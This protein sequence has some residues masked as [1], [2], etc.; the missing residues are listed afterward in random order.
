MK[1]I[2][3]SA[4]LVVSVLSFGSANAQLL[5]TLGK[6]NS[7]ANTA[8]TAA[9]VVDAAKGS[10]AGSGAG[11]AGAAAGIGASMPAGA[12]LDWTQFKQTPAIT[13][14]SLLYGTSIGTSGN[15]R[16][17][18][19]TATFVPNKKA[20]GGTIDAIRD[21][22][23]YLRVKVYKDGQYK[24]YFE[25][26]GTQTFDEGKKV[27][28]NGPTSR[29]QRAGE[30]VGDTDIDAKV[31]GVGNYRLDFFAG[32]KMF[33][34]FDFEIYKLSNPDTYSSIS[35]MYLT[36]GPWN[37]YAYMN[38][39]D[40]GNLIFGFY[41]NH[42]EFQPD[43]ANNRKTT[44]TV[45]WDVKLLKDGKPY[46]VQY[47]TGRNSA[48]VKQAEW[49][50]YSCAFKL[51]DKPGEVKSASLPDGS[52]KAVLTI[53]GEKAPR[54]YSFAVKGNRIVQSDEQD[55]AK[56]TDPTRLVEG[57]NDFFWLKLQK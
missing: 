41:L 43:P 45:K 1:Q 11:K 48:Q 50:D 4:L 40:T 52:Y 17:E 8:K 15:T 9:K 22:G 53:D 27:K 56:Q 25:Y 24:T 30:W 42:E 29:Y 5:K 38:Y 12:K 47:G 13:F 7:A 23:D 31:M 44:K 39:A 16:F 26:S 46:A 6:V 10:E 55:R 33:Y 49:S 35:E 2:K 21:Q 28:F 20:S 34:S 18:N 51:V 32:D 36:R 54:N 37:N 19:Y 14:N 3:M 57:W